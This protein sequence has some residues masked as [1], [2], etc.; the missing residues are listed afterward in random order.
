MSQN[1]LL[2]L[3]A[4]GTVG[5]SVLDHFEHQDNWNICAVSRRQ[6]DFET[7]AEWVSVDLAD[8]SSKAILARIKDVTHIAFAALYEKANGPRGWADSDHVEVN[9]RMLRNTVE[10]IE[11]S[12]PGLKHI[13]LLQGTKAYGGH[14]GPFRMPARESDP[15]YMPPN[16]YYDQMD[17]LADRQRGK[18]WVWSILRPQLVC[19]NTIGSPLN[20]VTAIGVFAAM[21]KELGMPLRFPGGDT[22]V[23]EATDARLIA[24]MLQWVGSEPRCANEIFNCA[25]GDVYV[26]E[27]VWQRLAEVFEMKLDR[28]HPLSLHRVM[29][30]NRGIWERMVAKH[31]LAP[32]DYGQLVPDWSFP[33]YM[34]GRGQRPNPH[35]MSTIKARKLGFHECV[36]T[37]DMFVELLTD[38]QDRKILP[39]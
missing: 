36:D 15:R 16:F 7:R 26:W 13:T 6:P 27:N 34:L 10:A 30:G 14:L 9:L 38:L 39:R 31:G 3:G 23:G 12:S 28:P 21:S 8:E 4:L 11:V 18:S 24:K 2:I 22:R 29:P 20:I 37:E 5:R 17:W 32:Y 35:H 25:N 19:G 1:K 33:D